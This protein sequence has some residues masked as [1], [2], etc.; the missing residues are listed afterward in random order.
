MTSFKLI[1]EFEVGRDRGGV[2]DIDNRLRA[3]RS[4]VL[5]PV[6]VIFLGMKRPGR[7][8]NQCLLFRAQG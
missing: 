7:G 6:G 3:G 8:A 5:I 4:G 1:Y 2:V